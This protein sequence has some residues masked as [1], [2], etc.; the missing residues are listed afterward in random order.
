MESNQSIQKKKNPFRQIQEEIF[1]YEKAPIGVP[2]KE[3]LTA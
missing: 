2:K 3:K 1:K